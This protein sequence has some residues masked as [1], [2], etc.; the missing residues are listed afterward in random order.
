MNLVFYLDSKPITMQI[1]EPNFISV[2]AECWSQYE[3]DPT[4][5]SYYERAWTDFPQEAKNL[6]ICSSQNKDSTSETAGQA[7]ISVP[8]MLC[9]CLQAVALYDME[10]KPL[11]RDSSFFF[12]LGLGNWFNVKLGKV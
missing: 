3:L 10:G 6:F 5:A 1:Q 12:I 7:D 11:I 4:F 8:G 2:T 9:N